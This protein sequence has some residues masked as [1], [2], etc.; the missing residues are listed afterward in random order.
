MSELFWK[1]NDVI[2]EKAKEYV[3]KTLNCAV[4]NWQ[5]NMRKQDF[6]AGY[7]KAMI[8]YSKTVKRQKDTIE[9]FMD[10]DDNC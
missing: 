8:E 9:F 6:I 5:T 1:T 3:F 2:E 7:R 10:K 4:S